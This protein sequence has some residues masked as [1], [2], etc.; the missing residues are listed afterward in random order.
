VGRWVYK[1]RTGLRV[2]AVSIAALVLVFWGIPSGL[3]VLVIAIVLVVVL[4]IIE[5][6]GR[7]PVRAD[8]A[9]P[10]GAARP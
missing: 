10:P 2:G 9:S 1:Y 4:G 6:I 8:L 7:P 3:T 5:L